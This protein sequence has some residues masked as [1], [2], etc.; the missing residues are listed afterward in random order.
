MRP[1]DDVPEYLVRSRGHVISRYPVAPALVILPAMAVQV[2]FFDRARPG[3]EDDPRTAWLLIQMMAKRSAALIAALSAVVLHRLFL[4]LGLRRVA[5]PAILAASLGSDL[6][7]VASQAPWQHGP[8]SLAIASAAWL[9]LPREAA[10]WRI[11]LASGGAARL[12]SGRST[13]CSQRRSS[14]RSL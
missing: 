7:A 4:A 6:W 12:S 11:A 8:A 5:I 14:A 3:W 10:R 13:S 9:L 1:N 2:A